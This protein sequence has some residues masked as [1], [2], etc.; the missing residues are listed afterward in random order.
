MTRRT[1]SSRTASAAP[2]V[3]R[4]REPGDILGLIPYLLGFHPAESLVAA[5]VRQRRVVVTARVDLAA[6]ADLEALIDQFELVADQVD[7]R[8]IV[9]VGYSADE[10]VRDVM[11]GLADVIPFDLVDVLAVSGDRWWSVCCDGD[12][13]PAEGQAYD[14]EAHPLA[15]E[16]VMAGISATGTRDD[17]MALTAGP[18][19]AER[20]RLTAAAEECA[21]KVDQLSRRRRRRRM[22]QLV[23]RVLSADGPTDAEAV[24]I[25]V[26]VRDIGVRDEVWAMMTRQ[27][28]EAYVALWRRVVAISV[29]PYEPAPLAMLGWA[30]WLDGNGALL[31][32]CI[33]RLEQVA[34]DYGLLELCKQISNNA[35]PPRYLDQIA[36]QL[37][38]ASGW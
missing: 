16:A 34:P 12:C 22:R 25:A 23:D 21:G 11:R 29:W 18:P 1:S 20:D 37:R 28:A 9:L 19:A 5:F 27:D 4:I 10:S 2:T 14:I 24:E 13:C 7:T 3:L 38:I 17:I 36:D 31:N 33:D 30:G 15:V 26:L 32:C 35:I 8:A 6:T